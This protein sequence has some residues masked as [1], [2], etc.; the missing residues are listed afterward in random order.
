MLPSKHLGASGN[1]SAHESKQ[2]VDKLRE[3]LSESLGEWIIHSFIEHHIARIQGTTREYQNQSYDMRDEQ[4]AELKKQLPDLLAKGY[5]VPSRA[6]CA[7]PIFVRPEADGSL[8]L[9]TDYR[10]L[11]K[12][13]IRD[14]YPMP[15]VHGLR[16][17][18]GKAIFY[19]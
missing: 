4:L 5:I 8:R 12:M 3:A 6:S 2:V 7:A 17:R 18:L 15:K 1:P 9:V 13:T 11:K 16:N 19:D 10:N 14:E